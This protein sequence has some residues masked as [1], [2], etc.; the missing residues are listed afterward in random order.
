M[1][2]S[3]GA[4][5]VTAVPED[6]PPTGWL[7]RTSGPLDIWYRPHSFAARDLSVLSARLL[8]AYATVSE[9]LGLASGRGAHLSIRMLDAPDAP[10]DGK[11]PAGTAGSA[12]VQSQPVLT[13]VHAPDQPCLT[14]EVD[15]LRLFLDQQIGP[16]TPHSRFWDAG[17]LGY[18]AARTGRGRYH[19]DAPA[20]CRQLLADGLLPAIP[21]LTTESEQRVS[22]V[23]QSVAVG[24]ATELIERSGAHAYVALVEAAR[25][26]NLSAEPAFARAYHR[27]L[28]LAERDW[29]RRLEVGS[30]VHRPSARGTLRRLVPLLRP[31]WWSGVVI[32][33]YALIG[34]AFSLALPLTF[35]FLIDDLL[36]HRPLAFPIPFIGGKGH[37]IGDGSEQTRILL[38]LMGVLG[39]LY[40]L[41]ALAR[42]R[43]MSVLNEVGESFV[44]DLR[45]KLLGVL[46]QLPSTYF[47]RTTAADINQRVVYDTATIEGAMV[48]ALVPLVTGTLTVLMNGVVLV[49]LEPRL[50]AIVLLGLPVLGLLYRLR[51][52]NLRAAAR[53]RARRISGLS[54]RVG[55]FTAM[56][57]LVKIYG[58]AA[59][60][61]GRIG[62][63]LEVHR[64][65]NIAYAQ[66]SSVLGQA[67]SLV[68]HLTQ[69]AVLLVGGYLVIASGG[70]DLGAGGLAAF[71]VVLGQI[72]GPVGQVAAA[73]QG[74]TDADA[75]VERVSE[76]LAEDVETDTPD[77]IEIGA[78]RDRL[79]LADVT[80]SYTPSAQPVLH[81]IS[82]SIPAGAT[83]AFVGPTGAGK[84]SIVNLLPRLY[85][86]DSGSI[87]WDG[88][89]IDG[90]S[91]ASLRR[92]IALVPQD[93]ILLATTVYENI[94]FG[95]EGVSEEDI[96]RAAEQAQA[97]GF[98]AALPDGYDTTVGERGAGLSGGQRQRI[99]LARALLRDPSV[100]ILDEATSALDATTQRAVQAGLAARSQPGG[101]PRTVVKIAHRLETV[102]D[103]DLIFVLDD[104]RLVE[105]G[106]HDDLLA[107]NGLYAQ[108]VADQVGALAD[109]VRPSQA[110]VARWLARLAPFAELPPDRLARLVSLLVR[111]EVAAGEALFTHGSASDAFF[112]IGR[113][114]ATISQVED[115]GAEHEIASVGPGQLVGWATFATQAA[116][117][118]SARAATDAVVFKLTRVA[119]EAVLDAD[120]ATP[121]GR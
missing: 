106:A 11:G 76:L 66:E 94:R 100:L 69:V 65:L 92:Q 26:D 28:P 102:A 112:L 19:A 27:A 32:L 47:A 4:D 52:R 31:Y 86:R 77:A 113:G 64:H 84:S 63:Q 1:T 70:Q 118:R 95:L 8:A 88:R 117:G 75:A 87:T 35:R 96:R 58:A 80:F 24:F 121:G 17:L 22:A 50:A 110:Q 41:N 115:D 114:R 10:L 13:L 60:F 104:G 109:A 91:L 6:R 25:R 39:L 62:R 79:T 53:E 14:P 42:V 49:G 33:F 89:D 85:A 74:L 90:A 46:S 78:L 36:G 43:L 30:R 73:R 55:E 38:G 12:S 68:M 44:L 15:L 120:P 98:I 105:Q 7:V 71:Y 48:N 59:Y 40:V 54:A 99:A 56:Q 2:D 116:H 67:A 108:L 107:R 83:V 21:E 18:V 103:A 45:R 23:A 16:P 9:L 5:A 51:R 3:P 82:L 72:F 101:P 20:R 81:E 111:M 97:H 57:V 34:I 61:A 37:V 119:Y 93:A 29:R